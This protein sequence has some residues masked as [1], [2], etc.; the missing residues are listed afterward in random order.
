MVLRGASPPSFLTGGAAFVPSSLG[1]GVFSPPPFWVVVLSP[2]S[3]F[4]YNNERESSTT[5]QGGSRGLFPTK[6]ESRFFSGP[7]HLNLNGRAVFEKRILL[8]GGVVVAQLVDI[9]FHANLPYSAGWPLQQTNEFNIR[10]VYGSVRTRQS[11]QTVIKSNSGGLHARSASS[12]R[13]CTRSDHVKPLPV[14]LVNEDPIFTH[15][16]QSRRS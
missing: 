3:V 6:A 5:R 15:T 1:G 16:R 9:D 13:A 8:V 11:H 7:A 10:E 4:S 2:H 12:R 14:I